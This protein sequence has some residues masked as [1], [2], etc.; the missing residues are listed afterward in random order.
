[1]SGYVKIDDI[2]EGLRDD[3]LVIALAFMSADQRV[4]A[5]MKGLKKECSVFRDSD[6]NKPK[7]Q[8]DCAW[9]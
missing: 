9:R 1:M 2:I 5:F 7:P 8:T 3:N 4:D 6:G